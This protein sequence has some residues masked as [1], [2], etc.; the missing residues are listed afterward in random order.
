[1]PGCLQRLLPRATHGAPAVRRRVPRG[2]YTCMTEAPRCK[3]SVVACSALRGARPMA[4]PSA[5]RR[6][7]RGPP[8]HARPGEI[9]SK[10]A[11]LVGSAR[12]CIVHP[13]MP[14]S[15]HSSS[16]CHDSLSFA[17]SPRAWLAGQGAWG[18]CCWGKAGR[19]RAAAARRTRRRRRS[20][21]R[22]RWAHHR[23]LYHSSQVAGGS[24]ATDLAKSCDRHRMN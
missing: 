13:W 10:P 18:A 4:A 1:M 11:C 6:V 3:R 17:A 5:Q 16:P 23:Y 19:W 12:A 21:P 2:T 15:G 22:S 20:G 7:V 9:R 24:M 8:S 14:P